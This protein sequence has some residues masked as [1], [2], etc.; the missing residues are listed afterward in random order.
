MFVFSMNSLQSSLSLSVCVCVCVCV[1]VYVRERGRERVSEKGNWCCQLT[2]IFPQQ[3][4]VNI[5][6]A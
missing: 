5:L 1:R 4:N 2:A 6:I 3:A